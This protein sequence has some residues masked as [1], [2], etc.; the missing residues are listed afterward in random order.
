VC[1]LSLRFPSQ[2]PNL[3]AAVS[4]RMAGCDYLNV[5]I[6]KRAEYNVIKSKR[7]L[8]RLFLIAAARSNAACA[9]DFRA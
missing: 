8:L 9:C 7:V 3:H 6:L 2:Q 5:Q 4:L 1:L